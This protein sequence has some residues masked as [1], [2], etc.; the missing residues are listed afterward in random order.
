MANAGVRPSGRKLRRPLAE[1][2]RSGKPGGHR[3]GS[4]QIEI[5]IGE[6]AWVYVQGQ[7]RQ[8]SALAKLD[9]TG[10]KPALWLSWIVQAFASGA[11]YAIKACVAVVPSTRKFPMAA[12]HAPAE[13]ID[14]AMVFIASIPASSSPTSRC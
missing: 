14:K 11:V 5:G 6:C 4:A 13:I 7:R 3:A 10:V 12:R 9:R 2:D 1:H 8:T